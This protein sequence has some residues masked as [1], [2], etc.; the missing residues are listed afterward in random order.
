MLCPK[1]KEQLMKDGAVYS[2]PNGHTYDI[3]K[4]G[5]TNLLL[6]NKKNT[7]FPG[8]NLELVNARFKFL[9][10]GFY[11]DLADMIYKIIKERKKDKMTILDAGC[12]VGYYS[13]Y[14]NTYLK[15]RVKITGI[16][17][18]KFAIQK[19][20]KYDKKTN[21]FVGSV[22]DLP[23]ESESQDIVLNI[24]S[25]KSCEEFSRVLK[26]DGYLIQVIQQAYHLKELK[27]IVYGSDAYL[28]KLDYDYDGFK[29]QMSEELLYE[30]KLNNEDLISLFSMT[31]YLYKT[32][33]SDIEKLKDLK[34]VNMTM[35]FEIVVWRKEEWINLRNSKRLSS[36]KAHR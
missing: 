3:S 30:K 25:P 19:A 23:V 10:K 1:C 31:P 24:F 16:D 29:I 5:Y 14:L 36:R 17:I 13:K 11:E 21:Y 9:N 2:C 32:R 20:A 12:G 15:D 4:E 27:E 35:N 6:V 34:E 7:Q 33:P 26:L 18:S 28:N 22:F 8:D